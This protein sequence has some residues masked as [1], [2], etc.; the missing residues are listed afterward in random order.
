MFNLTST[1]GSFH[2]LGLTDPTEEDHKVVK[3]TIK[4]F[5]EHEKFFE[6]VDRPSKLVFLPNAAFTRRIILALHEV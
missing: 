5:S 1:V 6:E 4:S 3:A 2:E